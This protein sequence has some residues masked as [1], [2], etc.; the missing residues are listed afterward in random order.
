MEEKLWTGGT[1][2]QEDPQWP[3][4]P[5]VTVPPPM[6]STRGKRPRRRGRRWKGAALLVLAVGILTGV[7][8]GL[9]WLFDRYFTLSD[10]PDLEDGYYEVQRSSSAPPTIPRAETG[11]GV[12]LMLEGTDGPRLDYRQIYDQVSPAMVSI[13][14][15]DDYSVSTGTGIV[16][17]E[18]G[19][20]LTNAHVV[21]GANIVQVV[22]WD[23]NWKS[24]S[25]V[26][27]DAAEDLAVLKIETEGLTPARFGD[28]DLLQ[29][30]DEVA[31]LGDPLGYRSTLTDGIISA[32]DR[33]VAVDEG[34]M[35]LIQ[36]SAAIN[37]GNSGGALL[38]RYGQVVGV[39]TI[40][41][42]S[43][44][45]SSEAL[46]FAIPSQRVKYVADRL[47][48]GEEVRRA[49]FGI[50]V[51]TRQNPADGLT[52]LSVEPDSDAAQQGI[53]AGDVILQAEGGAIRST[54]DLTRLK[55]RRGPGDPVT[56]T[57]L[58]E[59]QTMDVTVKL[60]E[61]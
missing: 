27:F 31:A 52:V 22:L 15:M 41:I 9:N 20:I 30:G 33:D 24:A 58:R 47:I 37:Y 19:Y 14:A 13:E 8:V 48:A 23:N 56:L 55:Q 60:M 7:G 43:R 49:A 5:K 61:A 25:L 45:G 57:I 16:L 34:T 10:L 28:S 59:G 11:T 3:V 39:T 17:T 29:V 36:T 35:T 26:G 21:A 18:D 42:V 2:E 50:T 40:K 1:W 46:G 38:N 51:D 4:P 53:V 32:L 12:A 44:D 54:Q 6:P